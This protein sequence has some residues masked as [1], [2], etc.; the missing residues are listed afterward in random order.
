MLLFQLHLK[1]C[2][3]AVLK[4]AE[5]VLQR[6]GV[7]T[8]ASSKPPSSAAQKLYLH[9][10]PQDLVL[11]GDMPIS[12][13]QATIAKLSIKPPGGSPEPPPNWQL[14]QPAAAPDAASPGVVP[15]AP[16]SVAQ[17]SLPEHAPPTSAELPPTMP[18]P[19]P[20]SESSNH[21]EE[22]P[23]REPSAT[24]LAPSSSSLELLASLTP[25][26][27]SLDSSLKGKPRMTKQSFLQPQN[28]E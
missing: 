19:P 18:G 14:P 13:I 25:E 11:G 24:S 27:F 15:A 22:R 5:Q 10:D 1:F 23:T 28:G 26:A 6:H 7:T 8:P 9:Q 17:P 2:Y 16:P 3:E 4:H 12:S 21:V 20:E